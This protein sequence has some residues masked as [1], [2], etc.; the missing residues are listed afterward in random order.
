MKT[1]DNFLRESDD[2]DIKINVEGK[3]YLVE[4]LAENLALIVKKKR[5]KPLRITTINGYINKEFFSHKG[6][7][8]ETYLQVTL[9]NKDVIAGKYNTQTKNIYVQIN[10]EDVYDLNNKTFDNEVL[11][12]KM[13]EKYKKHLRNNKF[14]INESSNE[15]I[16]DLY[17]II[18][19]IETT[20]YLS[21]EEKEKNLVKRIS[22]IVLGKLI[23]CW[24]IDENDVNVLNPTPIKAEFVVIYVDVMYDDGL[25]YFYDEEQNP[26][27][28]IVKTPIIIKDQEDESSKI[29]WFKGGKL[30][31]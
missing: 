21:E 27:N 23:V 3:N 7:S 8:Y 11:V 2:I 14:T 19:E 10:E 1:F 30:E 6:Y 20:D 5:T 26:Y 31:K 29:R 15:N 13:V 25:L 18:E 28:I 9:S 22:E 12:D 16:V 4:M 17:S 24:C